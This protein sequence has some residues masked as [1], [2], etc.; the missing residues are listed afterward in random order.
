MQSEQ[1]LSGLKE[2]ENMQMAKKKIQADRRTAYLNA[3]SNL[4]WVN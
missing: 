4:Q 2:K 3:K 1:S